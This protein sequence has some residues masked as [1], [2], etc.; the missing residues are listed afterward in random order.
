MPCPLK[1]SNSYDMI[2]MWV[3]DKD[4]WPTEEHL[5]GWN[6]MW[7]S[8]KQHGMDLYIHVYHMCLNNELTWATRHATAYVQAYELC[9]NSGTTHQERAQNITVL[10]HGI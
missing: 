10:S 1:S 4:V 8:G 5:L 3:A 2:Y 6:H 7:K 9:L